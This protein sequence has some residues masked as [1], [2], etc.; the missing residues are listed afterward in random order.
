MQDITI[1]VSSTIQNITTDG[2][3][4]RSHALQYLNG[5]IRQLQQS[6]DC[7]IMLGWVFF[8]SSYWKKGL[9]K[10]SEECKQISLELF[11]TL[12]TWL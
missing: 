4:S 8:N 7:T 6:T 10:Q 11:L 12:N 2:I 5:L 9:C 1:L 3:Y